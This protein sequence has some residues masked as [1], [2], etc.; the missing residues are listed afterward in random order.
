MEVT[1]STSERLRESF[2]ETSDADGGLRGIVGWPA[3]RHREC[4][5]TGKGGP[6]S[7]HANGPLPNRGCDLQMCNRNTGFGTRSKAPD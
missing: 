5:D 1:W 2:G 3:P 4:Q 7:S 6:C